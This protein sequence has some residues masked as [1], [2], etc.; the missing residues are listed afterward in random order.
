MTNNQTIYAYQCPCC[1]KFNL[2]TFA[3]TVRIAK[4]LAVYQGSQGTIELDMEHATDQEIDE[5]FFEVFNSEHG[6]VPVTVT[7]KTDG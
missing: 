3:D 1:G 5:Q 7:V 4:C 6:V 2:Q